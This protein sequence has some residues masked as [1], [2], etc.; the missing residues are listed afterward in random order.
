MPIDRREVAIE[1]GYLAAIASWLR[2]QPDIQYVINPGGDARRGDAVV[3]GFRVKI[4]R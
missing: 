3:A 2:V 1:A 4:G